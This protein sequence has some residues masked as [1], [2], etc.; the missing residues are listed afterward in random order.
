[1]DGKVL[2]RCVWCS[3]GLEE[4]ERVC[5]GVG[6]QCVLVAKKANDVLGS[7]K[8]SVGSRSGEV[9]LSLLSSLARPHL[10]FW[11][12]LWASQCKRDRELQETVQWRL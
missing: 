5:H 12:Q 9:L 10:E 1:M 4:L 2:V 3:E 8:R 6:Q 7:M 11:V